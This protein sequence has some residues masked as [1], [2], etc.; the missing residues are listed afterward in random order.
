MPWGSPERTPEDNEKGA[1]AAMC[2][3]ARSLAG[4]S[5]RFRTEAVK[6]V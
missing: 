3:K 4:A 6:A 2:L 5:V 1:K